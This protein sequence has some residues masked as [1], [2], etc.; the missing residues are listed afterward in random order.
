MTLNEAIK[1]CGT[2]HVPL[3]RG[4]FTNALLCRI[5]EKPWPCREALRAAA[6]CLIR[7]RDAWREAAVKL[8]AYRDA[9]RDPSPRERAEG[10]ATEA[11][12]LVLAQMSEEQAR[13]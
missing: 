12:R 9:W 13:G 3:L 5:C 2:G 4:T 10:L 7:D 1:A 11:H 6:E 8:A